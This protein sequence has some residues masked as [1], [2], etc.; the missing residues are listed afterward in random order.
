VK[1]DI[2]IL[3][4][5]FLHLNLITSKA[6]V[7]P[8]ILYRLDNK[9]NNQGEVKIIQDSSILNFLNYHLQTLKKIN[10]IK[11]CRISIFR[12]TGQDAR[13]NC[14]A[15]RSRFKSK[16]DS[17]PCH[18]TFVYPYYKLYVGDFRMESEALKFLKIIER[19]Y[20]DA[21]IVRETIISYPDLE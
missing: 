8:E 5:L 19:E 11:G 9:E 16:Y 21:F 15:V 14:M 4:I 2:I 3:C 12:D 10:G 20:P 13:K 18:E 6:Q 7:Q 1:S 17:I